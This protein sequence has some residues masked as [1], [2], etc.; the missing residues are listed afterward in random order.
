[1]V[2]SSPSL[3]SVAIAS[4]ARAL[5]MDILD[6]LS[7]VAL[8]TMHHGKGVASLSLS[9]HQDKVNLLHMLE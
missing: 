4:L 9:L 8:G 3:Q 2:I 6:E 1:M 7:R 5:I